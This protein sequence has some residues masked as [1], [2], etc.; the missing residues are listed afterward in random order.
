[1][2][3]KTYIEAKKFKRYGTSWIQEK[4]LGLFW[5]IAKAKNL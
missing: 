4:K 3:F 5:R 2:V 1:M